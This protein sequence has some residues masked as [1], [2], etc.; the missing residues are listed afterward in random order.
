MRERTRR[1]RATSAMIAGATRLRVGETAHIYRSRDHLGESLLSPTLTP[2]AAGAPPPLALLPLDRSSPVP[3]W[4]QLTEALKRRISAG[5]LAAGARLPSTRMLAHD[6]ELS[7]NT[8]AT[9]YEQLLADGWLEGRR[10]AGTFVAGR[11][12]RAEPRA[13]GPVGDAPGLSARGEAIAASF[14]T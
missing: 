8:V 5:E 9:A 2:N 3:A 1:A 6:L 12:P 10:G 7:R 4:R 14:A 11:L 13:P